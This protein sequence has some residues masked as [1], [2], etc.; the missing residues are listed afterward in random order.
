MPTQPPPIDS[1]TAGAIAQQAEL[2]LKIYTQEFNLAVD[3]DDPI[4]RALVGIL[5]RFSELVIQRLNQVPEKNFLAFL[6][7]LGASR[8]PPQSAR[9]PLTFFLSTG[10]AADGIVPARTQVA[11]PPA[12]GET[13]PV[14]FET[15]QELIVTAAKLESVFVRHPELDQYADY[16]AIAAA[17]PHLEVP[18]FR[19]DRPIQH[20]FY[21][22]HDRLFGHPAI[23]ALRLEISLEIAVPISR[24]NPRDPRTVRWDYWDGTQYAALIPIQDGTQNLTQSGT[25]IFGDEAIAHD[26]P[27]LPELKPHSVQGLEKRWLRCSLVEPVRNSDQPTSGMVRAAQLPKLSDIRIQPTLK[28][29]N[30]AIAAGFTNQLPIEDLSKDFFPFGQT[31]RLGDALYL[32]NRAAFSQGGAPITLTVDLTMIEP[33]TGVARPTVNA[34]LTWEYWN[35]KSWTALTVPDVTN[36]LFRTTGTGNVVQFTLPVDTAATTVNG[37]ENYWIRV[38]LTGGGY[39]T[40]GRYTP[41]QVQMGNTTITIHVFTPPQ[42][43]PPLINRL[44]IAYALSPV[45]PAPSTSVPE[46]SRRTTTGTI[47]RSRQCRTSHSQHFSPSNQPPPH[48][49]PSISASRCPPTVPTFRIVRSVYTPVWSPRNMVT[50]FP[51]LPDAS[52]SGVRGTTWSAIASSLS[53]NTGTE[54]A[55]QN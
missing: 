13:D 54:S 50:P 9:V 32:G 42:F 20:V 24:I 48:I 1:R 11:A 3:Q 53:G 45:S 26:S 18:V 16:S 39:G 41:T 22:A 17:T 46:R 8:L 7:L 5:A 38:R 47:S 15:E 28:Q 27:P 35:G 4:R 21:I 6:N 23:K 34:Q 2:L 40:E 12:A 51:W 30:L 33:P 36:A 43:V 14:L 55:G 10:S 31:P 37:I 25:I 52:V 49:P 19:G 29:T 44:T